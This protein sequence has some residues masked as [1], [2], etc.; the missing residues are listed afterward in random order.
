M[1]EDNVFDDLI[2]DHMRNTYSQFQQLKWTHTLS[3]EEEFYFQ[4]YHNQNKTVNRYYTPPV[5][6]LGGAQLFTDEG[7]TA[8]RYDV[9]FQNILKPLAPLRLVWGLGARRDEVNG[10]IYFNTDR[11]L[12][13]DSY[14]I[15][16]NLEYHLTD[17][18]LVNAGVMYEDSDTGG[19]HTSPRL[20]L[21]H[22]FLPG[23][24]LRLSASRAYRDPFLFEQSPDY[25][26]PAAIPN[27]VLLFDAG[28]IDSEEITSYE[29][30]Y[31]GNFPGISTSLD[32]RYFYDE[33]D[34]LITFDE[35]PYATGLDGTAQYF[36]NLDNVRIKGVEVSLQYRPSDATRLNVNYT[37]QDINGTD[38]TS[39]ARYSD[40]GPAHILNVLALHDFGAGYTASAGFYYLSEMKQLATQDIRPDQKR[41]DLRAG[42]TI[43]L[44]GNEITLAVV[45]QNLFDDKQDLRLENNIDRRIYGSVAVNFK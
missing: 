29:I 2:P 17:K 16:S 45:V 1:E 23:H 38:T 28:D 12:K 37:H 24:T 36:G 6:L 34:K 10:P 14:R 33:L 31:V 19:A 3:G 27:N 5:A 39:H 26:F 15:F 35:A 42:R 7:L 32:A 44:S 40:A 30:G 25:R 41:V 13:N 9:E 43:H 11:S 20:S 21:N 4:L 8:D 18:T 22:H